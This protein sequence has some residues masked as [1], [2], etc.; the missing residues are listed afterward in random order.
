MTLA[1]NERFKAIGVRY[2]FC[3]SAQ[4]GRA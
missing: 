4:Q 3:F 2:L 1:A